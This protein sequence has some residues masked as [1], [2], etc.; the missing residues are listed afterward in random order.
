MALDRGVL[1]RI[2]GRVLKEISNEKGTQLVKLPVSPAVWSTWRRYCEVVGVSM[3]G[4][5]AILLQR[6]LE[7]VVDKDLDEV[8]S[9]LSER[10]DGLGVREAELVERE[11]SV[12][13]LE[14]RLRGWEERLE[15]VAERQQHAR[16]PIDRKVG[17]NDPC[18]CGSG[19]KYKGCHGAP[20]RDSRT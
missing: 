9:L 6:E 2:D 1:A 13:S 19:Q 11:A 20:G 7:S 5:L 4:A 15:A 3:G 16:L 12:A 18:P 17:R 14:R 10:I 8:D